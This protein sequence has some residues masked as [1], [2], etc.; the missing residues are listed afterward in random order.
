MSP[1]NTGLTGKNPLWNWTKTGLLGYTSEF[2][3]FYEWMII[4][5]SMDVEK[6]LT[7]AWFINISFPQFLHPFN[8]VFLQLKL[9][10]G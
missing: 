9:K 4:S 2:D 5:T 10:G 6:N 8:M 7:I 1:H 3:E